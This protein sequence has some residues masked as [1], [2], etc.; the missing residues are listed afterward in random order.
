MSTSLIAGGVICAALMLIGVSGCDGLLRLIHTPE[1]IFADSKLYLDI[2]IYGLPFVFFYNIA[3]GIFSALGD[4]KTPF[5]FLACSSVSNI[6]VDILF[7]AK[8]NMGIAGVAWAT[9]LCQGVSCVLAVLFVMLRLRKFDTKEKTK[10]F[11][12]SLLGQIAV[13][14]VPSILQQSFI[15]VRNIFI[16]SVINTFGTEAVAGYSAAVKLNNMVVTS[17]TTLGNG[18]SNYTAQNVGAGKFARIK[19]GFKAG[20]SI[21]WI[22]CVPICAV[23]LS[24]GKWLMYAF[25]DNG[26]GEAMS[27]GLAFLHIISP[28]YFVISA[29]LVADGVLRGS[30]MMK[31]FMAA[32]FTD[33]IL[34]VVLAKVLASST[35][36]VNGIWWAWPVGWCVSAVLSI[37]FY[38][39]GRWNKEPEPEKEE[40]IVKEEEEIAEE[41]EGSGL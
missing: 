26:S 1:D 8:F 7:V 41:E 34:R 36:G 23:Y 3:T 21:V 14:A 13:I 18:I 35:L 4:S 37:L 12:F 19:Q 9:F 17:L 22:L 16:Q 31:Q 25:L 30:G 28:F 29:K 27:T 38:R 10:I 39:K 40:E 33:L 24:C 20:I 6:L 11:S 5:V 2:Y 32:T 15:S